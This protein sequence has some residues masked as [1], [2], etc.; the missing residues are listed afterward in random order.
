[1]WWSLGRL[2][3]RVSFLVY[4]GNK[5]DLLT[6]ACTRLCQFRKKNLKKC[7]QCF[8]HLEK[9]VFYV[10]TVLL[11]VQGKYKLLA[12]CS[13]DVLGEDPRFLTI[14]VYANAFSFRSRTFWRCLY[15]PQPA[16]HWL[17]LVSRGV[18]LLVGHSKDSWQ[19]IVRRDKQRRSEAFPNVQQPAKTTYNRSSDYLQFLC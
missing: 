19:I 9:L 2:D 18:G 17:V 4:S 8:I 3:T 5:C 15:K 13:Q 7:G 6:K 16:G 10:C 12:I 1:V 14:H 11:C